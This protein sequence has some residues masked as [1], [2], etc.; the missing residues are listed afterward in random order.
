MDVAAV[1]H[2]V[3]DAKA[4]VSYVKRHAE[5]LG[6][7]ATRI[8]AWGESAGGI[9]AESMNSVDLGNEASNISAAVSRWP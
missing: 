5:S 8:A 1:R 4:A 3:L 6:V 7:D 9:I 2:A